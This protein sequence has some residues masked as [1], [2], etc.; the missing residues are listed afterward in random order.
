MGSGTTLVEG[1]RLGRPS[2]GVDINPVA[3]LVAEAKVRALEPD[4]LGEAIAC[5]RA[6]VDSPLQP[7]LFGV[8]PL[9]DNADRWHERLR[10]WFREDVLDALGR[11]QRSYET[12]DDALQPFFRCALSHTL[13]PVSWWHDR[14]VKPTRKQ[15]KPIPDP[16]LVFF[17]HVKRMAR[18]NREYWQILHAARA[19][20]T[21]AEC[22]C[23][24]A[25]ALPLP[26][27]SVDLIVTSPPYVTSY[28]YADLH[29]LSA[30]WFEMTTDL[31]AFRQRFIGRSNGVHEPAGAM[32]SPRAERIVEQ[33]RLVNSRKA[34]EVAL[35]FAE[36]YACFTEWRRVMRTGGRACIVI[37]NTHLHGVEVQ[38]A[39]VFAEQLTTLGFVLEQVIL[40]EIPS[41]ILPRTR[42]R[43]T[44]KFARTHA[45]DY[46][47]YP[48]EYILVARRVG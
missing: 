36:M 15:D 7:S 5:V 13:K 29:Q 32:H 17:R 38:N 48:T 14:S 30:L 11:I 47:A 20:D 22:Y 19:H 41:K 10:Y 43:Q 33:L 44:G 40:R 37:G 16:T 18:G 26:D 24:D 21:P 12:L 46:I 9:P 4:L 45:A 3:H 42:D 27:Q 1:R 8:E 6:R 25:R 2:V 23:T 39:Q 34:R 35:Y 31:R 28:E